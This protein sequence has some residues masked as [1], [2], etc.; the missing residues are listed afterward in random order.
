M[1]IYTVNYVGIIGEE[2]PSQVE[3]SAIYGVYKSEQEAIDAIIDNEGGKGGLTFYK[4][5]GDRKFVHVCIEKGW[6]E[7]AYC[8][9]RWEV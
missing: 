5:K 1:K 3:D 2:V 9:Q 7:G 6:A 8:I 4:W